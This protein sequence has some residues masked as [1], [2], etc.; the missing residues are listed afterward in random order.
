MT[1]TPRN[2][3]DRWL[4]PEKPDDAR[5]AMT[6]SRARAPRPDPASGQRLLAE[7]Y[8]LLEKIGEGGAA[9]VYRAWDE[10]L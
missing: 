10:R 7:R 4:S 5:A 6:T 8:R 9:E 3:A 1:G 2:A